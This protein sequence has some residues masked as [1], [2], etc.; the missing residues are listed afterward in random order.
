MEASQKYLS[1]LQGERVFLFAD[2]WGENSTAAEAGFGASSFYVES[3]VSPL[4]TP[5]RIQMHGRLTVE[6]GNSYFYLGLNSNFCIILFK[7]FYLVRPS[8]Q[9]GPLGIVSTEDS[10][11]TR[12][13]VTERL[14]HVPDSVQAGRLLPCQ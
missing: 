13:W 14:L 7:A 11:C 12:A 5:R 6:S 4:S 2:C 9:D 8:S 10:L 3:L 1:S